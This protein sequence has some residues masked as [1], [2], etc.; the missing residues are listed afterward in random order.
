[1]ASERK[2]L[3]SADLCSYVIES[4]SACSTLA[5]NAM[6]YLS[7]QQLGV[8][9]GLNNWLIYDIPPQYWNQMPYVHRQEQA[10]AIFASGCFELPRRLNGNLAG[11]GID[12]VV[13]ETG[14]K[15]KGEDEINVYHFTIQKLARTTPEGEEYW[16][17]GPYLNQA[18]QPHWPSAKDALDFYAKVGQLLKP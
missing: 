10:V 16:M 11:M 14:P 7:S 15:K 8:L 1:M 9:T 13:H 18:L 17:E 4:R 3:P 6:A 2:R 12:V 5:P